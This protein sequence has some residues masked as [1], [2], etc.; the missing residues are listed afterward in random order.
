M[1]VLDVTYNLKLR[2]FTNCFTKSL[3]KY[4]SVTIFAW[5]TDKVYDSNT[6]E[7]V[8]SLDFN[9]KSGDFKLNGI[10]GQH[11]LIITKP[12]AFQIAFAKSL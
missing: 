5:K 2:I 8:L 7:P 9:N 4:N 10:Y 6:I 12:T 3:R 11:P 1:K